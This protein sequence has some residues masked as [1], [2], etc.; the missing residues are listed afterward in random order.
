MLTRLSPSF[1]LHEGEESQCFCALL[2]F[3]LTQTAARAKPVAW[4]DDPHH[5]HRFQSGLSWSTR[6][7]SHH[8]KHRATGPRRIRGEALRKID[9]HGWFPFCQIV[10]CGPGLGSI[11]ILLSLN[12]SC[13]STSLLPDPILHFQFHIPT[14]LLAQVHSFACLFYTPSTCASSPLLRPWASLLRH[15]LNRAPM[16]PVL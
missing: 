16:L 3:R 7:Q 6:I 9:W 13:R 10:A 2:K 12:P 15:L 1:Y 14:Q 4:E 5:A 11:F 8:H